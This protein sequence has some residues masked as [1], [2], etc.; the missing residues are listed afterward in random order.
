M[1][2]VSDPRIPPILS[3]LARRASVQS[4]NL[5]E[6]EDNAF[7]WMSRFPRFEP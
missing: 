7:D 2:T 6:G 4:I 3:F 1:F 5:A